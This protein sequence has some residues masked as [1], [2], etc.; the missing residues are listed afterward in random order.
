MHTAHADPRR[1][2]GLVIITLAQLMVVLDATI[3]RP[4]SPGR[5]GGG[6]RALERACAEQQGSV[7]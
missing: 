1:R 7:T 4:R 5:Q 6:E 3:R 2:S